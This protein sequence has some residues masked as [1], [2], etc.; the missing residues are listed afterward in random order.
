[1]IAPTKRADDDEGRK[2]ELRGA[3]DPIY[4][5]V[6]DVKVEA[7][8]EQH[9]NGCQDNE[10]TNRD[11]LKLTRASGALFCPHP[12]SLPNWVMSATGGNRT[13]SERNQPDEQRYGK[14]RCERKPCGYAP[15]GSST[16]VRQTTNHMIRR[17]RD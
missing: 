4:V 2:T 13:L 16:S 3:L 10:A 14:G 15:C 5:G 1:L 9:R 8:P 17:P 6:E 11:A 12:A 7:P